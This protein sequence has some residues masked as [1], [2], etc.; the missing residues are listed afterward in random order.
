MRA[1]YN[2]FKKSIRTETLKRNDEINSQALLKEK[3]IFTALRN[4]ISPHAP[5]VDIV[6]RLNEKF[7]EVYLVLN[8]RTIYVPELI[9]DFQFDA[10]SAMNRNIITLI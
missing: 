3:E 1:A 7:Y 10:N 8:R 4:R 2:E 6:Y 5:N 9:M